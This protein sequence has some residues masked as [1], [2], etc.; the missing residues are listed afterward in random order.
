MQEDVFLCA[1]DD[2]EYV[3]RERER[4]ARAF[5]QVF[6]FCITGRRNTVKNAEPLCG[7]LVA[8]GARTGP[9]TRLSH[10]LY[11]PSPFV[12]TFTRYTCVTVR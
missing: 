1:V 4:S 6:A 3:R 7:C 10:F 2:E 8:F 12:A 5:L 9:H 11:Q